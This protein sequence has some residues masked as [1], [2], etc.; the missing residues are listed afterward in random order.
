[1][2]KKIKKKT[3]SIL[4][5]FFI[6]INFSLAEKVSIIYIVENSPITNVAISNEI[7]YLLL[8]NEKLNQISKEDMVQYATKSILK[9]K[10]KEIELK[11]Y[12]EF[13]K[14]NKIIDQNLKTFMK[15]LNIT[16]NN[17]F[18][19]LINEIGL[20][21]EFIKKKIEIEFLWNQ[22]IVQLYANKIIVDKDELRNNLK[23]K[24]SSSSNLLKE[25]LLYEITFS[26]NTMEDFKKEYEEIKKSIEE[27]GFESSANIFSNSTSAKNGGKIGWVNE[28]QLSKNIII[29]ISQLNLG[30][31]S[32]PI[33]VASGNLILMIKDKKEIKNNLSLEDELKKA[34]SNEADKQFSQFSS[35]YFKKVELNTKIY[36]K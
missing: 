16:D 10:I 11:K 36:E 4:F 14:N 17:L 12:Y 8:I 6:S 24:I 18:D 35:I 15:R 27:I 32:D 28:N 34:I 5:F 1:M 7:K 23:K 25:Y 19:N 22:L 29:N 31:Y 2:I 3:I 20:S 30:E 33:K 26:P 21:K 9:E 13:G